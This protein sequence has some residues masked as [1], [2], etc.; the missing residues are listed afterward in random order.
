MNRSDINTIKKIFKKDDGSVRYVDVV[1]VNLNNEQTQ[2][3]YSY[4]NLDEDVA[5][6]YIK[7]A[8]QSFT[9]GSGVLAQDVDLVDEDMLHTLKTLAGNGKDET[10]L[11]MLTEKINEKFERTTGFLLVLLSGQ[12]DVPSRTTDKMALDES[13]IVYSY[14]LGLVCPL[15]PSKTELEYDDNKGGVCLAD[16]CQILQKPAASFLYPAFVEGEPDDRMI[17]CHAKDKAGKALMVSLFGADMPKEE[18]KK[19]KAAPAP[20]PVEAEGLEDAAPMVYTTEDGT[21]IPYQ[22][23]PVELQGLNPMPAGGLPGQEAAQAA[24]QADDAMEKVMEGMENELAPSLGISNM[25]PAPAGTEDAVQE[26]MPL[27]VRKDGAEGE[28][29]DTPAPQTIQ[30]QLING[31]VCYIIPADL[32]P[33]EVIRQYLKK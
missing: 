21:E 15:K 1:A 5:G 24:L 3:H 32:L 22:L 12:Y 28:T 4:W 26:K 33:I 31:Q 30:T 7:L 6:R 23:S 11:E 18:P 27:P 2:Y 29:G 19:P 14:V 17:Y 13:E 16:I 10:F 25:N 9:A 20:V 8:N